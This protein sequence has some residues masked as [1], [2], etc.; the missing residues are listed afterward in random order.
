MKPIEKAGITAVAIATLGIG[1]GLCLGRQGDGLNSDQ[2]LVSDPQLSPPLFPDRDFSAYAEQDIRTVAHTIII[3]STDFN[4]NYDRMRQYLERDTLMSLA[5]AVVLEE[6]NF[7]RQVQ[8]DDTVVLPDRD[9]IKI[10]N[11]SYDLTTSKGLLF[12]DAVLEM[13]YR[14]RFGVQ[15]PWANSDTDSVEEVEELYDRMTVLESDARPFS[16]ANKLIYLNRI[17]RVLDRADQLTPS[18]MRLDYRDNYSI[19]DQMGVMRFNQSSFENLALFLK[20]S[21]TL[22]D[23]F[24]RVSQNNFVNEFNSFVSN[25]SGFRRLIVYLELQGKK[26][27]AAILKWEYDLFRRFFQTD[28]SVWGQEKDLLDY[29]SGDIVKVDDPEER[30]NA[31]NFGILLRPTPTLDKDPDWPYVRDNMLVKLINNQAVVVLN[32]RAHEAVKMMQVETGRIVPVE[33]GTLWIPSIPLQRGWLPKDNLGAIV[34]QD[35]LQ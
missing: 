19:F 12:A 25:G 29:H 18:Q 10:R 5:Q 1:S 15:V 32:T 13:L 35:L 16:S 9:Q 3:K 8:R 11:R 21:S 20:R 22:F 7:F 14:Q 28:F 17:L 31:A 4:E 33:H 24:T 2:S 30:I 26:D 34:A 6:A 27:E 23:E